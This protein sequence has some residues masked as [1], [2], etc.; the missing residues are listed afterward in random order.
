MENFDKLI[1]LFDSEDAFWTLGRDVR[2][3]R[4]AFLEFDEWD[5]QPDPAA[6]DFQHCDGDVDPPLVRLQV[7]EQRQL[8]VDHRDGGLLFQQRCDLANGCLEPDKTRITPE[9]R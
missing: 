7:R 8:I 1:D 3:D 9:Q 2:V 4:I 6:G 5:E